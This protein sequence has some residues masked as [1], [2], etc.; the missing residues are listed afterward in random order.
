MLPTSTVGADLRKESFADILY[1]KCKQQPLVPIGLFL[2]CGALYL[3]GRAVKARDSRLANRMFYWRVFFQAFTV[4]AL[5][6]GAF[7]Y[8]E[9]TIRSRS[10]DKQEELR[11]KAKIREQLWLEE[12]DRIDKEAKERKLKAEEANMKIAEMQKENKK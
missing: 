7:Y 1:K 4:A 6:G 10:K 9:D 11:K 5:L 8:N 3:S 2:T 12:L